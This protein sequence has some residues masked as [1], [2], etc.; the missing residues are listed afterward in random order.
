MNNRTKLEMLQ[1]L[2]DWMI[3]YN[4]RI[5][6]VL[7]EMMSIEQKDLNDYVEIEGFFDIIDVEGIESGI[8]EIKSHTSTPDGYSF[9]VGV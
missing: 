3:K 4:V 2:K 6:C 8:S 9:E 5:S 7:P 1:E